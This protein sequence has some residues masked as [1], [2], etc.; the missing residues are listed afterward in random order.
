MNL[1]QTLAPTYLFGENG[2]HFT[3]GNQNDVSF[4][5]YYSLSGS[6]EEVWEACEY[7]SYVISAKKFARSSFDS[8]ILQ[9]PLESASI[10]FVLTDYWAFYQFTKVPFSQLKKHVGREVR[11]YGLSGED[12]LESLIGVGFPRI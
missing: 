6:L 5:W 4:L 11:V 12:G 7:S 9:I 8:L 10:Q 2:L 3:T 1:E